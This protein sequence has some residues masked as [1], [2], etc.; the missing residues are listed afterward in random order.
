M[1]TSKQSAVSVFCPVNCVSRSKRL[2]FKG[3]NPFHNSHDEVK[4]GILELMCL[5]VQILS[6]RYLLNQ[7]IFCDQT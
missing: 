5:C 4:G 3:K 6:G 7:A 1:Y 2:I